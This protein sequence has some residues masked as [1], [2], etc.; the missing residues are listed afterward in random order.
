[1]YS[2]LRHIF[3]LFDAE[4]THHSMHRL[5][6]ICSQYPVLWKSCAKMLRSYDPTLK[7]TIAG[8]VF[9]HP[10]GLAAGFDKT[11]ESIDMMYAL[12]FGSTEVGTVT[13]LPQAGNPHPRLFRLSMDKAILNRMGFNNNGIHAFVAAIRQRRSPIVV[14]GNIGKNKDTALDSAVQD[15]RIC[16][17]EIAPY[18]DYITINVS[19]PNTVGLRS[20]QDKEPLRAIITAV[21]AELRHP[22][23]HVPV[24][25]KIA[26]DLSMEALHD[27]VDVLRST[28]CDGVIVS[29]TTISRSGLCMSEEELVRYGDG[30]ISGKPLYARS[31][32]MIREMYRLTEG[33]IPIIGVGGIFSAEDAYEKIRAGASLVQVYT[34][35]IYEGPL[36]ARRIHRALPRLLRRDGFTHITEA[37]GADHRQQK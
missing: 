16:A 20:L 13:P 2:M 35:L 17:R 23:R 15:Y 12:E 37:V 18:V 26:P 11:G 7:Q 27:V 34:G 25:L 28:R 10:V 5:A 30:G 36:L 9:T 31:T 4:R 14:G 3:F 32:E 22:K 24:F 6:A 8:I 21:Q 19:S 1:M 33:R 29:N